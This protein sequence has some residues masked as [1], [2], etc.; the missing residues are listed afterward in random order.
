MDDIISVSTLDSFC[1]EFSKTMSNESEMSM[2]GELKKF[3][4]LQVKQVTDRIMISQKKYI[5]NLLTKYNLEEA[6][7]INILLGIHPS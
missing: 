3:L 6:K 1:D 7:A 5:R 4:D 2:M